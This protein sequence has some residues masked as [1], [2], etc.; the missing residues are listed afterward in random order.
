MIIFLIPVSG[1]QGNRTVL[2]RKSTYDRQHF[3]STPLLRQLP[4][5]GFIHR[6]SQLT[7]KYGQYRR[8][9]QF[10]D[11]EKYQHIK[12]KQRE[13]MKRLRDKRK[14]EL[15]RMQEQM[16]NCHDMY[17]SESFFGPS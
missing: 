7:S 3:A 2:C 10:T 5:S 6:S 16:S 17:Q 9:L 1:Q 13:S 11:P 12:M 4:D 8:S 14:E 15:A